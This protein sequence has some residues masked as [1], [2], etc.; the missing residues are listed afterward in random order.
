MEN[1]K[2][3]R[4]TSGWQ[5]GARIALAALLLAGLIGGAAGHHVPLEP[6]AHGASAGFTVSTG[7]T[8]AGSA[9][10][11]EASGTERHDG[12]TVCLLQRQAGFTA[13]PFQTF[14]ARS[15]SGVA[16]RPDRFV[17]RAG[18]PTGVDRGRAPPLA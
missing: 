16:Q 6:T 12:C 14:A 17:P 15:A 3:R 11:V 9:S 5:R 18:R 7:A 2:R 4:T 10:H 13:L 1:M 8:H